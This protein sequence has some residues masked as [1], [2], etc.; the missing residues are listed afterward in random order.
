MAIDYNTRYLF[1]P[2]KCKTGQTSLLLAASRGHVS[3]V[4]L[5]LD[6][7]ANMNHANNVRLY[8]D[9]TGLYS[10]TDFPLMSTSNTDTSNADTT[11]PRQ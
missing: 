11:Y 5:L 4:A 6:A 1:S 8:L 3:V 7:K 2:T 10:D 9:Y